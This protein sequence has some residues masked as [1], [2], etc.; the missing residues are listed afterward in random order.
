[1]TPNDTLVHAL[2]SL[3]ERGFTRDFNLADACIACAELD[4]R[5]HPG[6]FDVVETIRFDAN[7]DP[8]DSTVLYAIESRDGVRGTLVVPYGPYV[9]GATAETIRAL[10]LGA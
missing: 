8:D 3:Q 4:L 10:G 7:T 1:M 6:D 9:D 5:L 2:T